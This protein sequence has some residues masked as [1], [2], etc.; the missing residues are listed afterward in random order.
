MKSPK[1]DFERDGFYLAPSVIPAE[2][3][4]RVKPHV[5]AVYRGEYETGIPIAGAHKPT[6]EPPT[7]LVKID[8]SRRSDRTLLELVSHPGI[9]KWAAA[10]TGAKMVQVFA[11]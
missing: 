11:T 8:N 2:V 10:I 4:E 6:K 5:D 7:K 9:R 1:T 3:V